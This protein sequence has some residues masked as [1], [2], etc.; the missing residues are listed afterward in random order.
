MHA[1]AVHAVF[2]PLLPVLSF[3]TDHAHQYI[4]VSVLWNSSCS[5]LP[6]NLKI[7][8][9]NVTS[10]KNNWDPD[11]RP[12]GQKATDRRPQ[13][14]RPQD[15]RP[16]GQKATD[17]RPQ[18]PIYASIAL[19]IPRPYHPTKGHSSLSSKGMFHISS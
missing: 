7:I 11:K 13:D 14:K 1:S 9:R 17:K 6:V 5:F 18:L 10:R 12:H 19:L 16:H 2:G 8:L 4:Y 3:I 15:K